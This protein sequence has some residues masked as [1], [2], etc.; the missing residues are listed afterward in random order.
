MHYT[1]LAKE[2]KNKNPEY[3]NRND[4]EL[5]ES[6]LKRYPEEKDLI[7]F[8]DDN[9]LLNV[10]RSIGQGATFG[11][12]SHLAGL[13][14]GVGSMAYN[15]INPISKSAENLS[16]FKN[17]LTPLKDIKQAISDDYTKDY[18]KGREDFKKE[19]QEFEDKNKVL[20][21]GGDLVGGLATGVG[22]SKYL[23]KMPKIVALLNN[24]KIM[25]SPITRAALVGS[26]FGGGYGASNTL[27]KGF[28]FGNSVIGA[29]TGALG[30]AALGG[31]GKLVGKTTQKLLGGKEK[32]LLEEGE[33]ALQL[34]GK[35]VPQLTNAEKVL[36]GK[37]E[38]PKNVIDVTPSQEIKSNLLPKVEETKVLSSKN[39][40]GTGYFMDGIDI[41]VPEGMENKNFRA[42][43][44]SPLIQEEARKGLIG[45][46][47]ET[48]Q[49]QAADEFRKMNKEIKKVV[50]NAYKIIPDDTIIP[51]KKGEENLMY[52]LANELSAL[53]NKTVIKK[54][55]NAI[56]EASDLLGR[57]ENASNNETSLT[58]G[59]VKDLT[60]ELW[61]LSQKYEKRNNPHAADMFK[62]MYN[63]MRTFRDTNPE[64]KKA[65]ELYKDFKEINKT[66]GEIGF[67]VEKASNNNNI[68][69]RIQVHGRG[70]KEEILNRALDK[71][72]N[73]LNRHADNPELAQFKTL[74]DKVNLA[75]V[76]YD[77]RPT[78]NSKLL[79]A[80]S[81]LRPIQTI[82]NIS[83]RYTNPQAQE[84]LKVLA[85][86]IK[87]GKV[88]P[89]D[90]ENIEI[91]RGGDY[92][93]RNYYRKKAYGDVLETLKS[94]LLNKDVIEG[95]GK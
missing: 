32:A 94:N 95:G 34:E 24:S 19:Y 17:P 51:M 68:G 64:V 55:T 11:Q 38:I 83:D 57:I 75:Q 10:G 87:T 40:F 62:K 90:F 70:R 41:L 27:G 28:D 88:N 81:I 5:V 79:N 45:R 20:A 72:A 8:T 67:D 69:T 13:G 77:A 76:S 42:F 84:Q 14:E 92:A 44:K 30:G 46:K 80:F 21:L 50:D 39:P 63:H 33:K 3:S 23:P 85:A 71:V 78:D 86:R 91:L 49:N 47:W 59:N 73:I 22:T 36:L 35:E 65:T 18:E 52:Q 61:S 26:L 1:E 31:I 4:K 7:D 2:L 9:K 74:R 56:K 54:Q 48:Y 93:N 12:G 53:S 60:D 82:R 15:V 58:F 16:R 37:G 29:G 66:L 43:L 89:K 6:Y 25:R